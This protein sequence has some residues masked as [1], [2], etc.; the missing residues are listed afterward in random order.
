MNMLTSILPKT[1][2]PVYF[3]SPSIS[4]SIISPRKSSLH[5]YEKFQS[6]VHAGNS[7][8]FLHIPGSYFGWIPF[9]H[10]Q[11]NF[12]ILRLLGLQWKQSSWIS[13][14][15]LQNSL[16]YPFFQQLF[17]NLI[18]GSQISATY[19]STQ[20]RQNI[21]S[22]E[23]NLSSEIQK[24]ISNPDPE[25]SQR[26]NQING[27]RSRKGLPPINLQ[28][29]SQEIE[30]IMNNPALSDKEK[31][32]QIG[33]LRKKLGLSKKDM[34]TLFTQR[35]KKIYE[36][37]A[38]QIRLR[39]QNSTDPV[40]KQRL[41]QLLQQY[42]SKASLYNSM[43]K[44]FWSKLGGAFKKIG[45]ALMKIAGGIFK[46][47]KFISPFL[48]FIPGIG[49]IW[50]AAQSIF[51]KIGH[52]FTSVFS[53]LANPLKNVLKTS[54]ETYLQP[55]LNESKLYLQKLIQPN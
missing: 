1:S 2:H 3:S 19:N 21:P 38:A 8:S 23:Q 25:V 27:D 29:T 48:K 15:A 32:K 22:F 47:F 35:L 26:L 37:A 14:F 49:Q 42:E 33:A 20:S 36:S 52:F 4:T 51:G 28:S 30:N 34:K 11:M 16:Y 12:G 41:T 5:L 24:Q 50:G 6:L 53:N 43:F 18:K 44:S 54:Y 13:T 31:K 9:Q 10:V 39:L 45:S 55:W 40:E 46:V 17:Q 7:S